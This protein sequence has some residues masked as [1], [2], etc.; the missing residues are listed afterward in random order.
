MDINQVDEAKAANCNH[1]PIID[2]S[3]IDSPDVE[4]RQELARAVY[5]ACTRV[6]FF[7]IK[8]FE[9]PCL[10]LITIASLALK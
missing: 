7:Y 10:S 2:L 3:N 6:G 4:K 8:V 9:L 5:D 1:I